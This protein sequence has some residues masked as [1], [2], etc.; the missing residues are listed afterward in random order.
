MIERRPLQSFRDDNH[1]RTGCSYLLQDTGNRQ[2]DRHD[3]AGQKAER[4]EPLHSI[5]S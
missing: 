4:R 5:A 2:P 1:G 3:S